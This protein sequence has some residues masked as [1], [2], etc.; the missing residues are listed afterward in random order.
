MLREKIFGKKRAG[1]VLP[2]AIAA[3]VAV[4]GLGSCAALE[5]LDSLAAEGDASAHTESAAEA[6]APEAADSTAAPADSSADDAQ[7][8]EA[9]GEASPAD[10]SASSQSPAGELLGQIESIISSESAAESS[11]P[12]VQQPVTTAAETLPPPADSSLYTDLA[13]D[14]TGS[15]AD[16]LTPGGF[17]ADSSESRQLMTPAGGSP[18][19][20]SYSE[21]IDKYAS[22]TAKDPEYKPEFCR[23]YITD[24]DDNGTPELLIETGTIETDRTIY[25]YSFNGSEAEQLGNFV[26]W[27]TK[28]GDGD[29]VIYNE[30]SAMGSYIVS[31]IK[32]QDGKLFTEREDQ[33]FSETQIKMPLIGYSYADRSALESLR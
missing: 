27:H 16:L 8:G 1:R 29:G 14:G 24:I 32:I 3:V 6:P 18:L 5:M 2:A 13:G 21:L 28:L 30:T 10:V 7:P 20:T 17:S 23:Y 15:A 26:A 9:Q 33:P 25:V 4:F 31:T 11:T 22:Y 19:Y 12:E